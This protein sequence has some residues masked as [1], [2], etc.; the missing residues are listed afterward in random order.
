MVKHTLITLAVFLFCLFAT[1]LH[2]LPTPKIPVKPFRFG[3]SSPKVDTIWM[4]DSLPTVSWDISDMPKK[5]TMDIALLHH[6][7]MES[8][9][10]RRYVPT[11]LGST[12]V[13]LQPDIVPG[14][15]SLLLTVYNGRTSTVIGR[16]LVQSL[17]IVQDEAVDPEQEILFSFGG[18]KI[19]DKGQ[20]D[21]IM[22]K[23][24]NLVQDPEVVE[25]THEP[26]KGNLVLRAPYTVGWTVP[27]SL[28]GVRNVRVNI[29]LVNRRDEHVR[30]LA[31][32][33]DA[34]IGFLYVFLPEDI[35]IQSYKMK[36]E[37][38][39]NGRKFSG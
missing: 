24:E 15:Y 27:K 25:L 19:E 7:R 35:P 4:V 3:V 5:S 26:T 6:E 32:N 21:S 38:I 17:I 23:K 33:I 16:S 14:T 31:T 29:Q 20:D 13:N 2:A 1:L 37:I 10:L 34:K 8:V 9:L 11:Q 18:S 39:G 22:I 36:V 30:T 28:E 12:L